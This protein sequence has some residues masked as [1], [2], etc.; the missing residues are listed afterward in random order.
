M[1]KIDKKLELKHHKDFHKAQ[2]QKLTTIQRN[3]TFALCYKVVNQ[4]SNLL[5]FDVDEIVKMTGYKPTKQGD[6][7]Y[8]HLKKTYDILKHI[9]I[10]IDKKNGFKEF[11]LFTVFE[12][13]EDKAK[14]KIR[15]NEE[16]RYL[17][18][19]VTKPFT[20]QNLVEY[21]D[22]K[23]NYS[24]LM[25]SLFRKWDLKKEINFTLEEFRKELAIPESYNIDN[26]T[27]RVLTPIL[28]DLGRF[29]DDIKLEKIKTGRK[30]TDLKF[31]WKKQKD[32][33]VDIVNQILEP[34]VVKH[35]ESIYST[36]QFRDWWKT[37]IKGLTFYKSYIEHIENL[38]MNEV[39]TKKYLISQVACLNS[40][41]NSGTVVNAIKNKTRISE[42][43]KPRK[44]IDVSQEI[45]NKEILNLI[46][47]K[48]VNYI[49]QEIVK[50]KITK[51]MYEELY[52]KY[53]KEMNEEHNLFIRKSFD[54]IN[55]KKYEIV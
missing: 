44:K 10:K 15:V 25:Y 31:S 50:I 12:T 20:L 32:V 40:G 45:V 1:I 34:E 37:N 13:F 27:K 28:K 43:V 55:L 30:V 29:F 22:I 26:I 33:K 2:F 18:N 53:L 36:E 35:Y 47:D 24:Q 49:P 54:T 39:E 5:E 23:S 11:V 6:N 38:K 7:I 19:Q 4:E 21:T 9:S 52:K 48:N 14:V 17:L 3:L 51:E 41:V 16:Y 42:S 8:I 46:P